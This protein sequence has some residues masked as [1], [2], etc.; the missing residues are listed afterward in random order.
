VIPIIPKIPW[1]GEFFP[2]MSL[3]TTRTITMD[4]FISGVRKFYGD[5][6][7]VNILDTKGEPD[8]KLLGTG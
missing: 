5:E 3:K 8:N 7:M 6:P 1:L 4:E 2:S